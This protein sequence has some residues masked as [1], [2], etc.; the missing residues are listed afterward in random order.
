ML[1]VQD[2]YTDDNGVERFKE[3]LLVSALIDNFEY[4]GSKG[5]NALSIYYQVN[6][7]PEEHYSQITQLIGYSVCGWHCLST[8]SEEDSKQ[9]DFILGEGV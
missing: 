6:G 1:G 9:M 2:V 3:N 8:T 7:I 4:K 5:L